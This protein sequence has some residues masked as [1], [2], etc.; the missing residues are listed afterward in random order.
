MVQ[1]V[2]NLTAAAKV[3][4]VAGF[5]SPAWPSG[6]KDPVLPELWLICDLDSIPGPG[7]PKC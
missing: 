6:L 1:Q 7:T 3:A 5:Q 4:A 2:K